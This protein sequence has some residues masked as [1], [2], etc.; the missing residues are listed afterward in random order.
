MRWSLVAGLLLLLLL[1]VFI[2]YLHAQHR[3]KNGRK[4]MM[5]HKVCSNSCCGSGLLTDL[6]SGLCRN[7]SFT[8]STRTRSRICMSSIR[9]LTALSILI[10]LHRTILTPCSRHHT[11][12]RHDSRRSSH[13][14]MLLRS[15]RRPIMILTLQSVT[16]I[17]VRQHEFLPGPLRP[18]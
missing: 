10:R 7:G 17:K 6:H 12:I 2:S 8:Y 9:T 3:I 15:S 4:P 14:Q 5:Y 1:A 16:W 18:I 13:L 11:R